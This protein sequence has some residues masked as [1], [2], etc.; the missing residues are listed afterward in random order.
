MEK[1]CKNCGV[2]LEPSDGF[3]ASC[4]SP[5]NSSAGQSSGIKEPITIT[6]ATQTQK[7]NENVGAFEGSRSK[8]DFVGKVSNVAGQLIGST[9]FAPAT[10][11]EINFGWEGYPAGKLSAEGPIKLLMQGISGLFRAFGRSLKDKKRWIFSVVL[12]LVWLALTLMPLLSLDSPSLRWLSFATFAGGGTAGGIPG[13]IGGIVGKGVFAYFLTSMV[14]PLT[15]GQKPFAGL[16]GGLKQFFTSFAAKEPN[17]FS[18]ILAG[19]GAALIGYNLMVGPVSL[20][21]SM[22]GVA[23][24]FLSIRVLSG[25][26]GFLR[27]FA[28][29]LMTPSRKKKDT[30]T[31]CT[32]AGA[33]G[34]ITGWAAGFALA[35]PLSAIPFDWICYVLGAL[36]LI[37]AAVLKIVSGSKKEITI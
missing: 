7:G 27:R 33:L 3:C 9:M 10:A 36:L 1:Y 19:M 21:N 6:A 37:I 35:I 12:A 5:I 26:T 17:H 30:Q 31:K 24:F 25:R 13:M 18:V 32:C 15:R 34:L 8:S 20:Q 2:K 4:G 23:A 28:D 11:G 14:I 22:V 29:A 16:F